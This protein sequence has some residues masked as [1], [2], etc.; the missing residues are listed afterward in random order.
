[1]DRF[2]SRLSSRSSSRSSILSC[3]STISQEP[4]SHIHVSV[5]P[6]YTHTATPWIIDPQ[7][8]TVEHAEM[9]Q[10]QY[11]HVFDINDNNEEVY[12]IVALPILN[13]C[14]QGFNGTIFAYGMTGSGK[15]YSMRGLVELAVVEIFSNVKYVNCSLLEI[16]NEKIRDLLNGNSNDLKIVENGLRVKGLSEVKVE[17]SMELLQLINRGEASRSTDST[18]HNNASSR[19]HFIIMLKFPSADNS[20]TSILNLCDLAGSERATTHLD[21]RKEGSYINKSLLALGTVITR[22]SEMNLSHIP[23]RDSKLTRFLQPSLN[24]QSAVSILCTMQLDPNYISETTNTLRFALRAKNVRLNVKKNAIDY[25]ITKLIQ[26]NESLKNEILDLQNNTIIPPSNE[27]Y[28]EI[29]IENNI[30]NE[31][32]EHLKRLQITH[33]SPP[34]EDIQELQNLLPPSLKPQCNPIIQRISNTLRTYYSKCEELE[35]YI[36]HLENRLRVPTNILPNDDVVDEL[37]EEI[38]DLKRSMKRKDAMI[39]A[40]QGVREL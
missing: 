14:L 39:R 36:A 26:E 27:L 38:V 33:P 31:Q 19:S 18:D 13:K 17:S 9:G 3:S 23:Y 34:L 20:T 1:M 4:S 40:L 12:K 29:L 16:Y 2:P 5:R 37:R 7:R 25:D 22:L 10:F 35:S 21:R 15:T 8:S 30:L 32:I 24:G 6:K 28:N 11:D